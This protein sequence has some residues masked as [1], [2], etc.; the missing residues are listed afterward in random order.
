MTLF[1]L[2]TSTNHTPY[3]GPCGVSTLKTSLWIKRRIFVSKYRLP[4]AVALA[5]FMTMADAL[6]AIRQ[7]YR[8][9]ELSPGF[10]KIE[11]RDIPI[12]GPDA[13]Y[14]VL[15]ARRTC[16]NCVNCHAGPDGGRECLFASRTKVYELEI[17]PFFN[18]T[19][20]LWHGYE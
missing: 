2:V 7:I 6:A 9:S 12:D 17:T 5:Y 11:A 19:C 3:T 4:T 14:E 1:Y 10:I 18:V 13:R 16:A 20:P 8:E 15:P